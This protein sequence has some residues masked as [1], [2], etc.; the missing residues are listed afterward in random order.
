[1]RSGPQE[2]G[3]RGWNYLP[4]LYSTHYFIKEMRKAMLSHKPG[5]KPLY[6][7]GPFGPFI[8]EFVTYVKE[9]GLGQRQI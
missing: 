3:V 8:Q 4:F 6:V 5:R 7:G 1:M 9:A 2:S